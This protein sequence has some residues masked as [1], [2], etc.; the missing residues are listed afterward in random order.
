MK[1]AELEIREFTY[2]SQT[3]LSLHP[4]SFTKKLK[5]CHFYKKIKPFS[6]WV[7]Q[8]L[9]AVSVVIL[10]HFKN[11]YASAHLPIAP[12]FEEGFFHARHLFSNT[13]FKSAQRFCGVSRWFLRACVCLQGS[14]IVL[15]GVI[16]I[17][18]NICVVWGMIIHMQP[19]VQC[20]VLQCDV[21]R[22][23]GALQTLSSSPL[24]YTSFTL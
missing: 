23:C 2:F 3:P 4:D 12:S 10:F 7:Q 9:L 22:K 1:I 6:F 19:R 21:Y 16:P 13:D 18:Y 11:K 15:S 17:V 8:D 20:A 14:S 5:D 24:L